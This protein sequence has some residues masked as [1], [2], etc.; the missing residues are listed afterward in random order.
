MSELYIDTSKILSVYKYAVRI[1]SFDVAPDRCIRPAAVLRYQQ[2]AAEQHFVPAG[3]GWEGM[4]ALGMAFV[5]VRWH[6][7]LLRRPEM[8][9]A[10]TVETWHRQ[11]KGP[12][13]YR[14]YRWLDGS[15][16]EVIRGV[17]EFALV[18]TADHRLLRGEE[19]DR[20]SI[21]AQTQRQVDCADPGRLVLPELSGAGS[22]RVRP[23]D[24]DMNGHMNNTHYADLCEDLLPPGTAV[25]DIMLQF[26][27]ETRPG[28]E[29]TLESARQENMLFLQG[30]REGT[31]VFSARI[32]LA[33]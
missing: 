1:A 11:R 12:R 23:S 9:E 24:A 28:E 5:C 27:H 25:G 7:Q 32:E 29:I 8:G 22:Y 10:V 17:T 2:E 13:F 33:E 3:L 30:S 31:P 20:L 18:S 26:S 15:G 4:A 16:T 14:C 19:F 21:P 6:G